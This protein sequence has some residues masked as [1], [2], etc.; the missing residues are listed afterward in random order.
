MKLD[1][2]YFKEKLAN[3]PNDIQIFEKTGGVTNPAK[4]NTA[5]EVIT[6]NVSFILVNKYLRIL[7]TSESMYEN[8]F[9]FTNEFREVFG[10]EKYIVAY[11]IFGGLF[12]SEKTIHY[13]SPDNLQWED[14]DV[15]YGE[16]IE[17]I[18]GTDITDFYETFLWN[19]M[20]EL[21]Q[22]MKSDEGVFIYPFLWAKECDINTASKKIVP[23]KDLLVSNFQNMSLLAE[24]NDDI[25]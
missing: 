24:E 10:E 8:I 14:L 1:W 9:D 6:S 20:D 19:D 11:D 13:F 22:K 7:G 5:M 4:G 18:A 21:L 17:W 23:Y 3:S 25:D 15:S 2:K 12:A 16:F